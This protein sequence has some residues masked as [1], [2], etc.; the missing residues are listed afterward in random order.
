MPKKL[1]AESKADIQTVYQELYC[2][3]TTITKEGVQVAISLK[4]YTLGE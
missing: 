3:P 2:I 1:T 4:N